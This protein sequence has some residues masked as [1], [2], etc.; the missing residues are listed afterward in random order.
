MKW[1][2]RAIAFCLLPLLL[3]RLAW[4]GLS[5][6]PYRERWRERLGCFGEGQPTRDALWIHAV[7]VGEVGAAAPLI[8]ALR[9][10][11][12]A[13]PVLVTT[14]TPTGQATLA[15]LFGPSVQHVYFPYD[16]PFI[17]RRF[18]RRFEPRALLLMETELW[19]SLI[20][21]CRARDIPILLVNGRLSER[22]AARY[23]RLPGLARSM[24]RELSHAAVQTAEDA[25]RLVALGLPA[26]AVTVTG[27]LKFDVNLPASIHE[28][29]AALRRE[30]GV[31]RPVLMAGST[32]PGEEGLLLE[33]F[34]TLK[35]R[36]PDAMLLLAPRH[37]ERF[38][39][40]VEQCRRAGWRT[41]RRR[42]G[43][44]AAPGLDLLVVDTMGELLRFYAA[45]DVAFVG[46]S[47]LPFGGQNVL[48]PAG[49]GIPV[50]TGPHLFNF[51]DI[52][53]KLA[54]GGALRVVNDPDA[55]ARQVAEWFLDS[56]A[57]DSV[58]RAGRAIVEANRGATGRVCALVQ[59]LLPPRAA[60]GPNVGI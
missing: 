5:N 35:S 34:A 9:V 1:A 30:L 33:A 60:A 23:G 37:P 39:A 55:L 26:A 2:Y 24:L 48:E 19:P 32:R 57:R 17:V 31:N 4:R 40:V 38:D 12:A 56:D 42:D 59:D 36:F 21:A 53:D 29:G 7:S 51:A 10:R 6:P 13:L 41:G 27:S 14:T 11:D 16:L 49:L 46:G 8:R 20:H 47:L 50:I 54:N 3:L 52:G 44:A 58:G 45:C 15:R 43:L 25:T 18:L 28:E 22:S